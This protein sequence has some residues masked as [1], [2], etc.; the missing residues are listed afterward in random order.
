M[1]K[2]IILWSLLLSIAYSSDTFLLP[3]ESS[4][5]LYDLKQKIK[6]AQSTITLL[7]P[8]TIDKS[9]RKAITKQLS[10]QVTFKL[11]TSSKEFASTFAIYKNSDVRILRANDSE[12]LQMH[13]ILI[14]SKT[15]CLSTVAFENSVTRTKIGVI[16]CSSNSE[17]IVFYQSLIERLNQRSDPYF[18]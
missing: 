3:D 14:D 10:D 1:K 15:G 11:I 6:N 17:N 7:T 18:K 2:F 12:K 9:L 4:D 13:L 8:S 5:A 16:T